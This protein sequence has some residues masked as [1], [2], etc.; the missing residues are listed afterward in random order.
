MEQG[1][2]TCPNC[3]QEFELSDALTGRIR[4]HLE[5]ELSSEVARR[6]AEVQKK[7]RELKKLEAQSPESR[8]GSRR[9]RD[10]S[11]RAPA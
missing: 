10:P 11:E 3:G 1:K 8:K 6:E 2:I 4:A 9:N 5:A 7:R